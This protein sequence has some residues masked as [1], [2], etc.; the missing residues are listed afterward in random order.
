V[1]PC[2]PAELPALFRVCLTAPLLAGMLPPLLSLL[3][4]ETDADHAVR[5]PKL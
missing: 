3:A 5:L 1:H 4:D 2:R